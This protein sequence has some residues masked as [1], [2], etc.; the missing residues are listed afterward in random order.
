MKHSSVSRLGAN[1][2][3]T[4]TVVD[5]DAG[6]SLQKTPMSQLPTLATTNSKST[7]IISP[8]SM[9][10]EIQKQK[11]QSQRKPSPNK[12]NVYERPNVAPFRIAV[13]GCEDELIECNE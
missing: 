5:L 4:P 3:N 6:D 12:Q 9:A 10:K 11:R 2:M 8:I 1:F 7:I 13:H